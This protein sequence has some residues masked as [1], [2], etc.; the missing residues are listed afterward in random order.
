MKKFKSGTYITQDNYKSFQPTPLCRKWCIDNMSV[1]SLL[2]R[3][4]RCLGRLDISVAE[5][6]GL[7]NKTPQTA[8]NLITDLEKL[9][10]VKEITGAQ[11]NKLYSFE[12]YIHLF[13]TL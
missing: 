1:L 12:P 9:E 3:A 11:R 4:D 8:Y 13:D 5:A 10:I 7:I 2:S 6:T